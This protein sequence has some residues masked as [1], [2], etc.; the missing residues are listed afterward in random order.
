M[1]DNLAK[2]INELARIKN[3]ELIID[4]LE[5]DGEYTFHVY[6]EDQKISATFYNITEAVSNIITHWRKYENKNN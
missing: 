1:S 3:C 6:F 2:Q 4:T 5:S